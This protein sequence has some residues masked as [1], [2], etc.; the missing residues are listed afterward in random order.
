MRRSVWRAAPVWSTF[1][2]RVL[3]AAYRHFGHTPSDARPMLLLPSRA[4]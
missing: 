1:R 2:T 4:C 3:G